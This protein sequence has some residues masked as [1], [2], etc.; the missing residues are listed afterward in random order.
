MIAKTTKK[1][2]KHLL[3]RFVLNQKMLII[4]LGWRGH[5]LVWKDMKKL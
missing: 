5:W 3:K 4:M 2:E 1:L